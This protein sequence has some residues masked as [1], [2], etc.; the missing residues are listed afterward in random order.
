MTEAEIA[1]ELRRLRGP[2]IKELAARCGLVHST[3]YALRAGRHPSSEHTLKVLGRALS[4]KCGG[5]DI[6][7]SWL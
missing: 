6:A 7:A 4:H 5:R 3:L 1:Q 2:Q